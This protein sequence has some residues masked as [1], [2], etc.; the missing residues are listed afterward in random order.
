MLLETSSES[1]DVPGNLEMYLD[2][3]GLALKTL[4]LPLIIF[5]ATLLVP[6]PK[7]KGSNYGAIQ[8]L[9][10]GIAWRLIGMGLGLPPV[11]VGGRALVR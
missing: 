2:E 8:S 6:A 3:S 11:V 5:N 9:L 1:F 10:E 7:D 4:S